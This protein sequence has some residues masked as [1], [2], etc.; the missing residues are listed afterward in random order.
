MEYK[1]NALG[2]EDYR[3]LRE[4]VEWLPY[5]KE[6]TQKALDNSLY[7]IIAVDDDQ[8]IGMG[9]LIGDGVYY[10]IADIVV[11]P[12]HQRQGVGNKIVNMIIE[13]VEKATPIGGRSSIQLIAVKGKEAF[14]EKMGFKIIPHEFCG[15]GMRK[16]IHK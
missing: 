15:S 16:V 3:K 11:H 12:N 2:Y 1:E 8:T 14:Y 7:T 4:S 10:M 13:Y 6:Q 5:S 9:R